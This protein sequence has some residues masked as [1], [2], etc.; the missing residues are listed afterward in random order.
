M[1]MTPDIEL[2]G[3]ERE[4]MALDRFLDHV[5][6]GP[7]AALGLDG[8]PGIGKTTIWLAGCRRAAERGI[9]VLRSGPAA[10]EAQLSFAALPASTG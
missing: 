2:V 6:A 7:A 8:E 4:A 10:A 1:G 3:R 5:T 9:P